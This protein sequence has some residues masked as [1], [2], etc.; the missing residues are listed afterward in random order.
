MKKIYIAILVIVAQFFT[1]AC[2]D[3]LDENPNKSGND[4]ISDVSQLDALLNDISLTKSGGYAWLATFYANDDCDIRPGLYTLHTSMSTRAALG[5]WDKPTYDNLY[6]STYDWQTIWK[7]MFTF[8]TIIE[9]S[10]KVSGSESDKKMVAAEA[11]FMRAFYHFLALVEYCQHPSINNGDTP[12]IGYRDNTDGKADISR[13]TVKYSLSRIIQDLEEAETELKEIGKTNFDISRNWRITVPTVQSLRAR[14]ELYAAKTQSDFN[15]AA[16]YASKALSN[17][18][19]FV[20]ISTDPKFAVTEVAI[21]KST[22]KWKRLENTQN[23]KNTGDYKECYF[24]YTSQKPSTFSNVLPVSSSLYALYSD[25]DQRRIKFIDNNYNYVAI[26]NLPIALLKSGLDTLDAHSYYKFDYGGIS[27]LLGTT[28]AE[29][30]LIKAEAFARANNTAGAATELKLLRAKRFASADVAIANNIEGTLKDVKD[31][32]RREFPFS[33][34]WYD[35]KRYNQLPGEEITVSKKC[36]DNVYEIT[37]SQKSYV[38]APQSTAYA[39]PIPKTE[40]LLLKWA[41]NEY[42]GVTKN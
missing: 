15:K 20:D 6:P 12:G 17:Y 27:F 29:M 33:I 40:L 38:L 13:N 32:R 1:T 3:F 28:V 31:E 36:F 34:R 35:L 14:V 9:Y 42:S 19:V 16:E 39:M 4:P 21:T 7:N 37:T 18:D 2:S 23:T 41:E 24:P 22:K 26:T 25:K 5:V 10:K 30:H 8:N 11:K